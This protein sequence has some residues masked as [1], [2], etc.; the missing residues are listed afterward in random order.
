MPDTDNTSNR[1]LVIGIDRYAPQMNPLEGCVNDAS[2]MRD[3]LRD[4]FDFPEEQ[5]NF[6]TDAAA[7]RQGIL[8]G[9][10]RLIADTRAGDTVV[11]YY[12]GHGSRVRDMDGDES[13]GFDST[14][15]PVDAIRWSRTTDVAIDSEI[16]DITDD[17]IQIK[18]LR[19]SERTDN[20]TMIFDCCH[21]G[22]ISRGPSEAKAR[23]LPEDE[24]PVEHMRR[25][26]LSSED[27][28]FRQRLANARRSGSG[29]WAPEDKYV[30]ISGCRD[31][32]QSYETDELPKHGRLTLNLVQAL[33][34]A[35]K[36]TTFRLL[37]EEVSQKVIAK[38]QATGKPQH[39]QI[40][41]AADR[42]LFKTEDVERLPYVRVSRVDGR[43][44]RLAGGAAYGLMVGSKWV[45]I[46]AGGTRDDMKTPLATVTITSVDALESTAEVEG[47][48]GGALSTESLLGAWAIEVARDY[49]AL[50]MKVRLVG[51][52]QVAP[53]AWKALEQGLREREGVMDL[54][55]EGVES[56]KI[57]L[58]PAG[59]VSPHAP[60]LVPRESARFA[61]VSET[62]ILMMPPKPADSSGVLMLLDNLKLW[63][64]Y[65]YKLSIENPASELGSQVKIEVVKKVEGMWQPLRAREGDA[66]PSVQVGDIVDI[67]LHNHGPDSVFVHAFD[68][69]M[70]GAVT[71]LVMPSKGFWLR[72]TAQGVPHSL[73][74]GRGS[75]PVTWEPGFPFSP[76]PYAEP[77]TEGME[78][79]KLFLTTTETDLSGLAQVSGSRGSAQDA[80]NPFA[81]LL[82]TAEG[83]RGT[84]FQAPED[85]DTVS[86]PFLLR[87]NED[88]E[89]DGSEQRVGGVRVSASEA[90]HVHLGGTVEV[91]GVE[92]PPDWRED[93][94]AARMRELMG[95]LGLRPVE[96]LTVQGGS[97]GAGTVA[98]R[99]PGVESEWGEVLMSTD[100]AGLIRW[101]LPVAT[102]G[103]GRGPG[104]EQ[105]YR[106]NQPPSLERS[107][108]G[109]RGPVGA[110][111][112][113]FIVDRLA[114]P[115]LEDKMEE[116]FGA[117]ESRIHGNRVRMID[118]DSIGAKNA[119]TVDPESWRRLGEGKALFL[120]HGTFSRSDKAFRDLPPEFMGRMAER[121][122]NRVFAFDHPTVSQTPLDNVKWFME[123][124]PDGLKLDV[125]IVSHS[126]GGLL[127]RTLV[128]KGS[129]FADRGQGLSFGRVVMVGSPHAGTAM[130]EPNNFGTL[131][132]LFT[133]MFA[134]W[135]PTEIA[136][137]IVKYVQRMAGGV[138]DGLEG[139][140]SMRPGSE[141]LQTLSP[142]PPSGVQY[143]GIG[144]DVS[145]LRDGG[146]LDGLLNRLVSGVM[147]DANDLVVPQDSILG[148]GLEF[149]DVKTLSGSEAVSH[150]EYFQSKIVRDSITEWLMREGAPLTVASVAEIDTRR[151]ESD[152]EVDAVT[153]DSSPTAAATNGEAALDTSGAESSELSLPDPPRLRRERLRRWSQT[154]PN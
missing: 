75:Q 94:P 63:A 85:W 40:E 76:N 28:A 87:Q 150:V 49:G 123:Q 23:S 131:L 130:A 88:V 90:A 6:L 18:L 114:F 74:G 104:T 59:E 2:A 50:R 122:G 36:G 127:A 95:E 146:I 17:E 78:V 61:A 42:K 9:F 38:G 35:P 14:V 70:T 16:L 45:V 106:I 30:L 152:L 89:L 124:M 7:T 107:R 44:L 13:E 137:V 27:E 97:R 58:I 62:G 117:L 142:A 68:F 128:E 64:E 67:R 29:W 1:A 143:Y 31:T 92:R 20:I 136:G 109:S 110:M 134:L 43:A 48:L 53:D 119:P 98:V 153:A 148:G 57:V 108:G 12:A 115:W 77:R 65:R 10:D 103:G 4:V 82:S 33:H 34:R 83:T 86:F 144:S 111:A 120:L 93:T 24:R 37:F 139:L 81:A 99:S 96:S 72:P 71:P 51:D 22:T 101:H 52:P 154:D 25:P 19:L 105:V 129:D 26:A 5:I 133:N 147:P 55:T 79:Y 73:S 100:D 15:V 121:Y 140:A 145:S 69:Q 151:L 116:A 138:V 125:D 141:F 118:P 21:S 47:D 132:D 91:E 84:A 41:G 135:D 46:P 149:A 112:G 8:D 11:I 102:G 60:T 39:P 3:V 66:L 54:A 80:G 56:V 126:R 32:E 113:K